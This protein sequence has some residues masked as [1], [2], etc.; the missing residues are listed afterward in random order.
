[1]AM[2][3]KNWAMPPSL[4]MVVKPHQAFFL[5]AQTDHTAGVVSIPRAVLPVF[6]SILSPPPPSPHPGLGEGGGGGRTLPGFTH[7]RR[8]WPSCRSCPDREASGG[9]GT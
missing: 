9:V 7:A 5:A 4:R 1:M 3:R 6:L 2:D 8:P